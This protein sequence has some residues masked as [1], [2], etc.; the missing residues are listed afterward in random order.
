MPIGIVCE[1]NPL[2]NGH[3]YQI[4]CAKEM[5]SSLGLSDPRII[6]VMSGN[7]VQRSTPAIVDKFKRTQMAL[8]AGASLVI[9]LPTYYSTATAEWFAFGAISLLSRSSLMDTLSFGIEDPANLPLLKKAA[10]LLADETPA[11]KERLHFYL[12]ASLPFARARQCALEDLLKEPLPTSSNAIL[13]LEYLKALKR[14]NASPDLLPIRRMGASHDSL[15]TDAA[16][17][18]A[19]FIRGELMQKNTSLMGSFVPES[20]QSLLKGALSFEED[21]FPA[22]RFALSQHTPDSMRHIDEVKEGIENRILSLYPEAVS[23]ADLLKILQTKRYPASRLRRILLNT[24]LDITVE[25]KESVSFKHGP[26]YI[27]VLGCRKGDEDLL[28]LLKKNASLPVMIN[29]AKDA[30]LLTPEAALL[31]T[32]ELRF[33]RIYRTV[34]ADAPK[35]ELTQAMLH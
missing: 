1:Y 35:N 30:S 5:A 11:Y 3:A 18:S 16:Y 31:F 12:D 15:E 32:E 27:R 17:P 14:L 24:L 21:L 10:D 19:S 9:E 2:H 20:V 34:N 26:A 7:F 8:A 23:Y 25:K 33:S 22:L 13:A 28:S 4:R 29:P 6:C